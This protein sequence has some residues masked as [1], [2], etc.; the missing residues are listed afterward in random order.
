MLIHQNYT[1]ANILREIYSTNINLVECE[2]AMK[3]MKL[4]TRIHARKPY[5]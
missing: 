1:L 2:I 5:S 4:V 3:V